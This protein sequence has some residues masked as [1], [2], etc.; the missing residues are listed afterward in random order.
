MSEG[1]PA[2]TASPPPPPTNTGGL[3]CSQ[4]HKG[5]VLG[6]HWLPGTSVWLGYF[7][8]EITRLI[9]GTF[10]GTVEADS[11]GNMCH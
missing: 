5:C 10:K 6:S 9:N 2:S 8:N 11:C 1:C 3:A 4:I 7:N